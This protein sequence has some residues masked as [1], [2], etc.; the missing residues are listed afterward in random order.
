MGSRKKSNAREGNRIE[1][2]KEKTLLEASWGEAENTG[3]GGCAVEG[4]RSVSCRDGSLQTLEYARG[5]GQLRRWG[6]TGVRG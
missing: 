3:I 4:G 1:N 5:Y 2:Q 6:S